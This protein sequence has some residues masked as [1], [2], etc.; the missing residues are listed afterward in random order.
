MKIYIGPYRNWFG[1]YQ[2]A[3]K[4][5][6][7]KDKDSDAVFKLGCFLTHGK[8]D[9]S[10]SFGCGEK[11]TWF[12]RFFEKIDSLKKRKI[13]IKIHDYDVWNMDHT[14][15]LIIHPMLVRLK[16]KKRGA[17]FVDDADVPDELKS[18]SVQET[19][20]ERNLRELNGDVDAFWF[21]RWDYILDEMIFSFEKTLNDDYD[22]SG[23]TFYRIQNGKRLFGKYYLN[24]WD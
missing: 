6:F 2:L 19:E 11:Y 15:S 18:T 8:I 3:Q 16:E 20:E 13:K 21:K 22:K 5:L 10:D 4:L 14:L 1:P 17:P 7:W 24:L 23:D 9:I 12:F